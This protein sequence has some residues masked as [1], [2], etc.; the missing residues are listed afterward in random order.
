MPNTIQELHNPSL[1][2]HL[3]RITVQNNK[4]YKLIVAILVRSAAWL[5]GMMLLSLGV[6]DIMGVLPNSY[7]TPT[8][9]M[10]ISTAILPMTG[11]IVLLV[12]MSFFTMGVRFWLLTLCYSLKVLNDL[13]HAWDGLHGFLS[14]DRH[15]LIVATTFT[16]A[17]I[18]IA[19]LLILLWLH[20]KHE[21]SYRPQ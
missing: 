11:G 2:L 7:D 14:E 13:R 6:W 15:W 16:F 4:G 3:R 1:V 18:S 8:L 9:S 10:R 12:P 17:A 5:Y 19:N 20:Q 21:R